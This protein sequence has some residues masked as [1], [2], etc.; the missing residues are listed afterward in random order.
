MIKVVVCCNV[1]MSS[2][3]IMQK[4]N[5]VVR[6]R[7]L[8]NEISFD[9]HALQIGMLEAKEVLKNYDVA[10]CCT[11]L[12]LIV[13]QLCSKETLS[14]AIYLMPPRMFGS[15][16][17]EELYQDV[18]DVYDSFQKTKMN[19]FHFPNEDNPLKIKR[20]VAYRN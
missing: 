5:K 4:L 11:H 2:S 9:Y 16:Y 3:F 6:E 15:L 1:G 7:H 19:P 12:D 18:L 13:N 17:F 20:S 10:L 8:E 14:C